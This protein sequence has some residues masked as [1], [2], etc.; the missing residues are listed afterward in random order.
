MS[1]S[2]RLRYE[3]LRRDNF[4]C[5]YCGGAAPDV[6]ITVDHVTP[7]ALGGTDDPTNLVTA[8][9]DCNGGKSSTP[10]DAELIANVEQDALRWAHALRR[11]AE[12]DQRDQ[13][14]RHIRAEFWLEG[15]LGWT[16]KG[17]DGKPVTCPLPADWEPTIDRLYAAGLTDDD[18]AEAVVAAMTA[19]MPNDR[20][21]YFCGVCWNTVARRQQIARDLLNAPWED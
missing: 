18:L 10:A 8:C 16:T 20:F 5:R 7:T 19:Y 2:K 4:T 12:I 13:E 15:W 6:P 1:I 17:D 9:Q 14:M 11:A 3:V 21:R